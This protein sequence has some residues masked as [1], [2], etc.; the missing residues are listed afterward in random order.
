MLFLLIA[1]ALRKRKEAFAE[2]EGGARSKVDPRIV[3]LGGIIDMIFVGLGIYYAVKCTSLHGGGGL[4]LLV[5]LLMAVF[6]H[7]PYLFY[8]FLAGGCATRP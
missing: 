1:N 5:N 2:E 6:F 8:V 7:L 3:L 4:Y